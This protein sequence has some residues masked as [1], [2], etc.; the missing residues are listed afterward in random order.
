M[1]S[2]YFKK[3]FPALQ[4]CTYLNT[5]YSGL[6]HEE[7]WETRQ[8]HELDFLI[9][10]GLK[11]EKQA[12]IFTGV[13]ETV[14]RFFNC[15]ANRVAL[16]PNFSFGF[17]SLLEGVEPDSEILLLQDDY[18]SISWPVKSRG[19][20]SRFVEINENLEENIKQAFKHKAPDVFAFS[21]VQYI[22]GILIDLDFIKNLKQEYPNTLF[23]ADGTQ[24]CGSSKFDFEASGLDVM[25]ASGYKWLN[26]GYGNAFALFK[27]GVEKKVFPKLLGFNSLQGKYKASEGNFIGR[28]EPGHLDSFNFISLEAALKL[29]EEIGMDEI[30]SRIFQLKAEVFEALKDLNLL[31]DA[32]LKRKAHSSIFNI[33][34]GEKLYNQLRAEDIIVS[35]RG[36]GIR[37][38]FHYYNDS[39]DLKILLKAL[40]KFK[41]S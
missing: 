20:K 36:D 32:V 19:F 28:F 37:L 39:E 40:K 35:R 7:V 18:P 13:R 4:Q 8:E 34:G 5:A 12:E 29:L 10:G 38:A 2:N 17:N 1:A 25:L 9:F 30:E 31:E 24:F 11:K 33:K 22:N 14:G 27:S 41:A 21:I 26:A 15:E 3:G 6:L 16:L 23:V